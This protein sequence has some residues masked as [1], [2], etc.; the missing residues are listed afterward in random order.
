M[1]ACVYFFLFSSFL[2][3]FASAEV[4]Q[5]KP[6][7]KTKK[8]SSNS[9][10]ISLQQYIDF[11]LEWTSYKYNGEALPKIKIEK[12]SLV[13]V[14]F[15][16]DY[17]YAQAESKGQKLNPV[18]AFYDLKRKTI[19]VSDQIQND[20]K[21]MEVA[22]VHEMVHYLQDING[23]TVSLGEHT[24][25]TESEAYDVQMLWQIEKNIFK[26]EVPFVQ[27]RSLFSAM[28][29]MGNMSQAFSQQK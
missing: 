11:I 29:C 25:C 8:E 12:H 14:F 19:Y 7:P 18:L 9:N 22:L 23:Y 5:L 20:P 3:F 21:R 10:Q 28:Q 1:K 26:E 13:Q 27:E 24:V 17:V 16:G 4:I 2:H 6:A 15:Y